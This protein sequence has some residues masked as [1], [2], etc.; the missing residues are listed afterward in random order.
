MIKIKGASRSVMQFIDEF[1][2]KSQEDL[3]IELVDVDDKIATTVD[4][5]NVDDPPSKID[6]EGN[7]FWFDDQGRYHR[8]NDKPAIEYANGDKCWH[9]HNKLHRDNDLP[10]VELINGTKKWY[11]H[12]LC[13]RD[14]DKPAVERAGCLGRNEWWVY[15]YRVK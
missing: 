3:E 5:K 12:G 8:D 10:A 4:N 15:G 11:K 2:L 6:E 1:R 14:N 7:K 9:Q 13:H